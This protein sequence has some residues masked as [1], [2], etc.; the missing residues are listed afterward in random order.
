MHPILVSL[1]CG[2]DNRS[3]TAIPAQET[4]VKIIAPLIALKLHSNGTSAQTVAAHYRSQIAQVLCFEGSGRFTRQQSRLWRK[5]RGLD[6]K[7]RGFGAKSSGFD[8]KRHV[9]DD[10]CRKSCVFDDG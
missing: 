1:V 5:S 2:H 6:A 8:A 4:G 10:G 3:L 9:F 7:S